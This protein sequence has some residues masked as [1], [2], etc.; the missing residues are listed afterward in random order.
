[1]KY[2]VVMPVLLRED[3]HRAVVED[4][5]ASVRRSFHEH[6]LI[7]VDDGSP[8]MS[9]FLK[10]KAD[11]YIRHN[12][13]KG[14]APSWNDGIAV[15]RGE[16]VAVIN[17]DIQVP[18]MWL[19]GLSKGFLSTAGVVAPRLAGPNTATG[20]WDG[21]EYTVN[22]KFYPGYCFMLKRDR[23]LEKFDEQFVPFNF[24][25]TDYWHRIKKAGFDMV[26]APVAIWHKE[27][28]VLHKLQY[29]RVNSDNHKKFI[30]K[31]GFDPQPIYY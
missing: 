8:L 30:A 1:M 15:S 7:I 2:S 13:T 29:D 25:D 23:F 31:W 4:C 11:V 26:R 24:E 22:E 19:E 16:Y 9:G 18:D 3:S 6:E 14:I 5:I 10:E 27:G 21:D 17:D 12:K 20:Y 28:D